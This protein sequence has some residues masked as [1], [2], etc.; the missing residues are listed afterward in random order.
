MLE[1]LFPDTFS[2]LEDG[3]AGQIYIR[4]SLAKVMKR[5]TTFVTSVFRLVL[6]LRPSKGWRR[7][8]VDNKCT[9]IVVFSVF[10]IKIYVRDC[11]ARAHLFVA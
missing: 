7:H 11:A 5:R 3:G 6:D 10:I 4:F 1:D 9:V 8:V 2:G